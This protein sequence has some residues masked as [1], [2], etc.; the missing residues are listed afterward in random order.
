MNDKILPSPNCVVNKELRPL[1]PEHH[2]SP[3]L[4]PTSWRRERRSRGLYL[5]TGFIARVFLCASISICFNSRADTAPIVPVGVLTY[6]NDNVRSGLNANE[7]IL[8]PANVNSANFARLFS[9]TVDGNVFADPL[10]VPNVTIPGQGVHNVLIIATEHD[11]VYAFDADNNSG[12]NASPLWHT[13]FLNPA[14]GITTVPSVDI[15]SSVIPVEV[16]ITGTP[17]IDPDTSTIYLVA[18]TKE[19][20]TGVSTNY[21]QRLHALDLFTG[22]EK[23]GGPVVINASVP[24]TGDGNVG[25]TVTFN[26]LREVDRSALLLF[27]GVIYIGFASLGDKTPYHGWLLG[28]DAHT[29]AQTYVFNSNPNGIDSGIWESGNGPAVDTNGFIYVSTGNG[30]FDGATNNDYADSLLKLA[31]SN[32]LT[33]VDFFTPHDQF[34]LSGMDL[35]FGSGGMTLLPDETGSVAHP[36]LIVCAGKQGTIY[37][38]DRDNLTQFNTPVDL[39]VQEMPS[40]ILK[41]WGSP[42]Y[43]NHTVYFIGANDRLKAFSMSNAVIGATVVSNSVV[44]SGNGAIPTLS[45]NGLSNGIVWAVNSV[46]HILHAY[47]GTNVATEFGVGQNLTSAT[48]FS[49][50]VV[51]NGKVYVGTTTAAVVFGLNTPTI[52]TQPQGAQILPGNSA[53]FSVTANSTAA[54]LGYQWL[55]NNTVLVNQTN[56]TLTINNAQVTDAGAYSVIVSDNVGSALSVIAILNLGGIMQNGDGTVTVSFTGNPGQAYHLESTTNLSV[57]SSWQMLP[58]SVTNAPTGG[59]WQYTDSDA[60]NHANKF[61][62]S[63]SP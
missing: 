38:V 10:I 4:S 44:Y 45:A 48:K 12:A 22:A 58:G 30:T 42:A 34:M 32:T 57:P 51:A 13:N 59:V 1:N 35:D 23:F 33:L 11:S 8:T 29:L 3:S 60:T 43:F 27:N 47:N 40:N 61:Y 25:G 2:L 14:A 5:V 19:V 18:R 53:T 9:Q 21:V 52:T 56:S 63:V 55:K 36:H 24:G 31:P 7:A 26:G 50:P 37:L 28:Y 39:V 46:T 17:V 62:R 15:G 41:S 54:P 49:V 16:G 6:H 20:V